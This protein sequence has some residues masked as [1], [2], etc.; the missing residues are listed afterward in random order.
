MQK[1]YQRFQVSV[2]C[3]AL[4]WGQII[5]HVLYSVV[6]N[7][8]SSLVEGQ[9]STRLSQPKTSSEA[10]LYLLPQQLNS[11]ASSCSM[12]GPM[13]YLRPALKKPEQD[14]CEKLRNWLPKAEFSAKD[15]T[16]YMRL[17]R[18]I[19]ADLLQPFQKEVW[20]FVIDFH[21][22]P[23]QLTLGQ[24]IKTSLIQFANGVSPWEPYST[25]T[26]I[27]L[28]EDNVNVSL[29]N[30]NANILLA[31]GDLIEWSRLIEI[32]NSYIYMVTQSKET[33]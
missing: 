23:I 31:T 5:V 22:Y 25:L 6:P 21:S 9:G 29:I 19:P 11:V 10:E 18:N 20:N 32:L 15:D 26:V 16:P 4:W 8:A 7:P 33:I 12:N 30:H 28:Y 17:Y 27:L 14:P 3:G 2:H 13:A 1:Y 24:N